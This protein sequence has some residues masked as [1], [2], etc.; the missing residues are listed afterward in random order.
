MGGRVF[1]ELIMIKLCRYFLLKFFSC[2]F[3]AFPAF[4]MEEYC[5]NLS[6]NT[7]YFCDEGSNLLPI[8]EST[9]LELFPDLELILNYPGKNRPPLLVKFINKAVGYSLFA[10]ADI[11]KGAFVCEYSGE[12]SKNINNEISLYNSLF[13][14]T[15]GSFYVDA[16]K[17]GGVGRFVQHAPNNLEDYIFVSKDDETNLATANVQYRCNNSFSCPEFY[18][19]KN[20]KKGELIAL[21]YGHYYWCNL[22]LKNGVAFELFSKSGEIIPKD[23]YKFKKVHVLIK[24]IYD[25]KDVNYVHIS[26]EVAV[27]ECKNNNKVYVGP[28]N[29][30]MCIE[31]DILLREI[32]Q[33]KYIIILYQIPPCKNCKKTSRDLKKCSRCKAA[34]YCDAQCQKNNWGE[35]KNH[36]KKI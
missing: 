16:E 24:S 22:V 27:R 18:A 15:G 33:E 13:I 23:S 31:S 35:H 17:K 21:D 32:E 26:K 29:D 6:E 7:I 8:D 14:S 11:N 30:T 12:K 34:Y 1:L 5:N 19:T 36:C 9:A 28:S 10:G 3:L 25:E 2:S 20:I 4:S